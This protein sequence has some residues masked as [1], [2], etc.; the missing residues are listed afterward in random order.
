[1]FQNLAENL[2]QKYKSFKINRNN[3]SESAYGKNR[4]LLMH[5][6][7]IYVIAFL[8]S[9]MSIDET[10]TPF[11][12]AIFVACCNS[13]V[14]AGIV[15]VV[16]IIGNFIGFG[17]SSTL[18]YILNVLVFIVSILFFKP[19]IQDNRNEMTKLGKNLLISTIFV[20]AI[21]CIT[22]KDLLVYDILISISNVVLTYV[23]YKIF[24]NSLVVVKEFNNNKAFSIEE[25]IGATILVTIAAVSLNQIQL[26]GLSIANI[27]SIFMILALSLRSGILVGGTTGTSIGLILGILGICTP[28]EILA[29]AISGLLAGA[30]SRLGKIATVIGFIAGTSIIAYISTGFAIE[31]IPLVEI[32]IAGV[33]FMFVPKFVGIDIQEIVDDVKLLEWQDGTRLADATDTQNR[34]SNISGVISE[35]AKALGVK[36]QSLLESEI[37]NINNSKVMFVEDLLSNIERFPNNILYDDLMNLQSGILEDI[38]LVMIEKSEMTKE[39]LMKIFEKRKNYIVGTE[40]NDVIKEDINQIIR[41]INRTYR[42][43][44]MSF[45]WKTRFQEHRKTMSKQLDGVSKAINEIADEIS[46]GKEEKSKFKD[47]EVQI[48]ELLLQKGI[49]IKDIKIKKATSGKMFVD[50]YYENIAVVKEKDKIKCIENIISKVCDEKVLLQKDTS[51]ID[52]SNYMQR[53]T[54]EDKFTMQLGY[55]KTTKSGNNISGDSSIQIKLDDDKCLIVLSDG[56]GSGIE[57]RKSSQIVIKMMKKLLSA[58]FDKDD[59]VELINSTIKLTTEEVYATIDTSIFDLYN[60]TVEFIKNGACKTYIKNKQNV[61]TVESNALPLG[62]LN[63]VEIS[64][65]DKDISDGDIFVM[66]SDGIIDSKEEEQGD[67]WFIKLLKNI[68]TNNVQK[69]AD[70]LLNEAFDNNYGICKDDMTI[71]VVKVSKKNKK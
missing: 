26:F 60:G 22:T 36:D 19:I 64:V 68:S 46:K 11:A 38:Y 61:D 39:D 16:T 37:D 41:I 31:L 20:Q 55:A 25:V 7:V 1:M 2:T 52:A 71:I 8:I 69:M 34:L 43:N 66:C 63:N 4:L 15:L 17:L 62:I 45:N 33:A 28:L 24:I 23:F 35:M 10:V 32:L 21:K 9:M 59:S 56:M 53:Y 40:D 58:G 47:K 49:E 57:A 27:I 6:V 14:P 12:L 42:I 48:R 29:Y 50:I 67:K 13:N 30:L 5:N 70:I 3:E 44:E 18:S 65:F 54:S 51:N